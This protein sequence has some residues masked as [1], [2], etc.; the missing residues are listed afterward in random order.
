MKK[1][2]QLLFMLLL[3]FI[4]QNAAKAQ[5]GNP[6]KL[7][8]TGSLTGFNTTAT[9]YPLE[10]T[11]ADGLYE[12]IYTLPEQ[13]N[14]N[15]LVK[16]YDGENVYGAE[17][18]GNASA[19]VNIALTD[20]EGY[21]TVPIGRY[22][23]QADFTNKTLRLVPADAIYAVGTLNGNDYTSGG[24]PL[25][26]PDGDGVYE[27][28]YNLPEWQNGK[29]LLQITLAKSLESRLGG[30]NFGD[31]LTD[32]EAAP[33]VAEGV[34]YQAPEGNFK[35][36]V[37]VIKSTITLTAVKAVAYPER[38]YAVGTLNSFDWDG[39]SN[40]LENTGEGVYEAE[41]EFT[42][43]EG[44]LIFTDALGNNGNNYGA[45]TLRTP[46]TAGTPVN[47]TEGGSMYLAPKGTYTVTV[48][49]AEGTLLF[50][51]KE[52]PVT[53]PEKLYAVGTHNSFGWNSGSN[54]LESTEEGVYKTHLELTA[55]N[56]MIVFTAALGIDATKYGAE[57]AGDGIVAGESNALYKDG[58]MFNVAK[59]TYDITVDLK[60]NTVL[61]EAEPET[62]I[63]PERLYAVGT[64]NSFDWDGGSNPLENTEEGV[65]EAELEFTA[66]EGM[67]IF[68]DAL[69][70]K[71]NNYGAETVR[72]PITAGIPVKITE[73]GSMYLAPK[74]TYTVTVNLAE[75]TL[76]FVEKEMPV[77]FP[78][79][80]YAVGTHNS[81]G[82][83]SGSNPLESTEEGVY[84]TH[85]ELTAD[86]NMIVFTAAL[87][88]DAT[89][90]GAEQAGDG[91]V[92]GES[93]ALYKDGAMFNVAKGTYDITVDLKNNTVLFEAEPEPVVYPEKLYA[94]GT[95]N[96]F[97]WDGGSNPLESTEEGVY[98]ATL[99]FTAEKNMILFADALTNMATTYGAQNAGDEITPDENTALHTGG[100]MFSIAKGTYD[101]TVDL[102]NSTIVFADTKIVYPERLYAVGTLNSF[103]WDGGSNP[104]ESTGEGIYEAELEFATEGGMLVFTD[105]PSNGATTY[106]AETAQTPI[107]TDEP[108]DIVK[109]G[110]M[111]LVPQGVYTVTVNLV[112]KTVMFVAKE[113]PVT[114][115][116][117]LYLKGSFSNLTANDRYL[118]SP[119]DNEGEYSGSITFDESGTINFVLSEGD[120]D[121]DRTYGSSED[122]ETLND[123]TTADV[124]EGNKTFAM[125]VKSGNIYNIDVDLKNGTISLSV[126]N[127]IAKNTA[128]GINIT[129]GK[130]AIAVSGTEHFSVYAT[131]G[132][133]VATGAA[134]NINL[135]A[136]VYIVR[137][138][139]KAYKVVVK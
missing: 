24:C 42:A 36:A 68:T 26:D 115:P 97:D 51:E 4:A 46:I 20:G 33:L 70:N 47:I 109:N 30:S 71:G 53:F 55:D 31:A 108:N 88:I 112:E 60:N 105:A 29:S 132:A 62:V 3:C 10:A 35:I 122:G 92:A 50:I 113:I 84:K 61:F 119:T 102:K 57:Q 123:K 89:K 19:G 138:A 137:A 69:E 94:V 93:N 8:L 128:D 44:M 66:E 116:E 52:M 83:N 23:V 9:D 64:L 135:P 107:A 101:V 40:P 91:I 27:G 21:Y 78:E 54:P 1:H 15:C 65:Y 117:K 87:G 77:T 5:T 131:D 25:T 34:S 114:Y 130:G 106:G 76:L 90:Y 121:G 37:D 72:T 82:W 99:E 79:K 127:G 86:N 136:G 124:E 22:R 125:N 48:N 45:E 139:G 39:G 49:I 17:T 103:D 80:L 118:L 129:A 73:G 96:S 18:T 81:F 85:L 67:L 28:E 12:G 110:S 56:N 95:L 6:E 63:Y 11:S 133:V 98:K 126:I 43:E 41:L 16:V 58:A 134:R 38:L 74:G 13:F 111:Y 2:L 59:G 104:L 120:N 14:G 32:G 100:A 7:Y 75:G